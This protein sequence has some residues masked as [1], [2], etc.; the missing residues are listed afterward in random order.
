MPTGGTALR[1]STTRRLA[2][3]CI[4]TGWMLTGMLLPL[5]PQ[6]F[7]EPA[8]K[9]ISDPHE[10]FPDAD[11]NRWRYHGRYTE[12][13]IQEIRETTFVNISTV[14]GPKT[15]DGV[16][17]I[18]FHDSNP[19]NQGP[20]DSYYRRDHAGI[21]YY[22]SDPSTVLEE[23]IIPYQIIRFPLIIPS[24]FEQFNRTGLDLGIDLDGDGTDETVDVR[25]TVTLSSQEPVS[26]PYGNYSQAIRLEAKMALTMYLSRNGMTKVG[27]DTMTAWFARGIGLV[28][29]VERQTIP[30]IR[31]DQGRI[32]EIT[33]EL[34]DAKITPRSA[35]IQ[36]RESPSHRVFSDHALD[37]ELPQVMVPTSLGP[38][39]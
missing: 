17:V 23:Q 26:V 36:G 25:A 20:S 19:G 31:T 11:G 39:P 28:K 10:F 4:W 22:G 24:S 38:D 32:V 18:V 29:Y 9:T 21:I 12:G 15:V 30:P 37:H 3:A 2:A 35:S 14:K 16:D 27:T 7:A 34:E 6:A 5:V 8:Q 1:Q 13:P 33:E